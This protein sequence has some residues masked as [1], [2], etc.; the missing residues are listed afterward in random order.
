MNQLDQSDHYQ[1]DSTRQ[2][3]NAT[4]YESL[5]DHN[6]AKRSNRRM[7][8]KMR[9]ERTRKILGS[10]LLILGIA[11]YV[12]AYLFYAMMKGV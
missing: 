2:T 6:Y 7:T 9:A 10:I 5:R 4:G 8:H 3:T 1:Y 11:A 12:T